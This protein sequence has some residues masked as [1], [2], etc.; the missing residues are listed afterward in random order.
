MEVSGLRVEPLIGQRFDRTRRLWGMASK[1][2]RRMMEQPDA[3]TK[4][5]AYDLATPLWSRYYK[6]MRKRIRFPRYY[7]RALNW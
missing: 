7:K 1:D 4:A 6:A 2:E 3:S 5:S